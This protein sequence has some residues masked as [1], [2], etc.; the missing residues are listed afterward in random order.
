MG[1]PWSHRW[2]LL[3]APSVGTM[4]PQHGLSWFSEALGSPTG[5]QLERAFPPTWWFILELEVKCFLQRPAELSWSREGLGRAACNP[6]GHQRASEALE[7]PFP[8]LMDENNE[9]QREKGDC[10]PPNPPKCFLSAPFSEDPG[11]PRMTF[12]L[13]WE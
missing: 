10:L 1:L 5:S 9:F 3:S 4:L 12:S 13:P 8:H 6:E 11:Q 7:I 2:G